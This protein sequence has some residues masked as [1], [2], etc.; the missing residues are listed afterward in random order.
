MKLYDR[1]LTSAD[2]GQTQEVQ[3]PGNTSTG[4]SGTK[5]TGALG[6]HVEFSGNLGRL[7]RTLSTYDTGRASHVRALATQ[8]QGGTYRPD[9]AATSRAMIAEAVSAGTSAGTH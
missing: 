1:G 3:K 7:S 8:Y 2:A 6:D 4:K 5:G 9:S